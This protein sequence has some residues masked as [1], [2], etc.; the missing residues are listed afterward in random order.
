MSAVKDVKP[1]FLGQREGPVG[2]LAGDEGVH[3]FV[4]GQFQIAPAPP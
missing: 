3:P 1:Q 4:R 2:A